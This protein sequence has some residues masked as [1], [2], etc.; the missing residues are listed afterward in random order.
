[1]A[2]TSGIKPGTAEMVYVGGGAGMAPLR[3]HLSHLFETL[4]T[5]R[6]VSYWYGARSGQE[7]FYQDYFTRLEQQFPNF[8]FHLALSDPQAEDQWTGPTGNISDVLLDH[9]LKNHPAP[10]MIE[11]YLCGPPAMV[12]ATTKMLEEFKVPGSQIAFD[13]F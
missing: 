5:S 11:Y 9:H 12:K 10:A 2:K 3:S 7:V 1:M 8:T 4:Q 13:E 6:R